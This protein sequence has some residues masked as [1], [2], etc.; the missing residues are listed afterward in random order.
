[1]EESHNII[2]GIIIYIV[3]P[4]VGLICYF[5][6]KKRMVTANIIEPPVWS[7]FVVFFTYGGLL[8][9]ILTVFFWEWSGGASI[10]VFYLL[11]LAPIAMVLIAYKQYK[12]RKTSIY[13]KWMF[14][15]GTSYFVIAPLTF[16]ILFHF[17]KN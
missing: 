10:G 9:L 12:K 4:L 11:F 15:L 16:L 2:N 3:I 7:M 17:S 6:L 5:L 8:T 13:H 14:Y 1:M